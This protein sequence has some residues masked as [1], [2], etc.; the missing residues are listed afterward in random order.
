[1]SAGQR[2]GQTVVF[3]PADDGATSGTGKTQLAVRLAHSY[4]E[5]RL[6]SLVLWIAASSRDAVVTSYAYTLHQV[7]PPAARGGPEAEAVQFLDWLAKAERPWLIVFDDLDQKVVLDG[8]WPKGPAGQVVVTTQHRETVV[9]APDPFI[10]EVG[11]YHPRE[12]VNYLHDRLY[13]Y[14]DQ[15]IG[16]IELVADMGTLPLALELAATAMVETGTDCREYHARLLERMRGL[17]PSADFY[18]S[19]TMAAW[20]LSIELADSVAPAGLARRAMSLLSLLDPQGVPREL[21][22][23]Q[24]ARSYLTQPWR[25]TPADTTEARAAV[26][27]LARMGLVTLDDSNAVRTVLVHPFLQAVSRHDLPDAETDA[28]ARAA[29]DALAELW[30]SG[31]IWSLNDRRSLVSQ[32][33]RDS[34]AQLDENAG[35]LLWAPECH[36]VLMRAGQSLDDSGLTGSAVAYWDRVANVSTSRLGP[37]HAQTLSAQASLAQAYLRA[38]RAD[39]AI[40][41]AER[42]LTE[43]V[44]ELGPQHPSTMAARVRVAELYCAAGEYKKAV[45]FATD[46]LT[47][48]DSTLGPD[49]PD[50]I[51]ACASLAEVYRAGGQPKRAIS[52]GERALT[53]RE[54]VQGRDHPDTI[55]AR[56]S[57]ASA[58]L[59]AKKFKVSVQE[60]ELALAD[61]ERVLGPDHPLTGQTRQDLNTA[62]DVARSWLGIDL[63]STGDVG[64][65]SSAAPASARPGRGGV[66]RRRR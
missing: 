8:L 27:N 58:Y 32:A 16:A 49:H 62:A 10:A 1:M 15:R 50:T 52:F 29:A 65:R 7:A 14:H 2:P 30:S 31:T 37:D 45:A 43:C 66:R 56:A 60:Y 19:V 5:S 55:A 18:A 61:A 46:A 21:L 63:R 41:L 39:D 4:Q 44:K 38:D 34:A 51:A 11:P 26:D 53:A 6:D 13:K 28:T 12:A 24:S 17:G 33:L 64:T 40:I 42:T 59:S 36:P 35:A 47:A 57:L 9:N 48:S 22:V 3:V 23:T 54:R 20:S 25:S